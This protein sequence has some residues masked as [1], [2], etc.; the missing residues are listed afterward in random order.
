MLDLAESFQEQLDRGVVNNRAELARL[1]GFSRAR[2]T[3]LMGL[4]R[5]AP[6]IGAELRGR[7]AAGERVPSERR[8]RVL[9][10]FSH[11][12]QWLA[13]AEVLPPIRARRSS[14]GGD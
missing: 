6:E 3:Q 14:L 1:H 7:A 11:P 10:D 2:V 12:D 13:L 9:F 5:L 8:L 4:L